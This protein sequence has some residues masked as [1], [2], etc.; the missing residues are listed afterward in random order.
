[1]KNEITKRKK[2]KKE[3]SDGGWG[4]WNNLIPHLKNAIKHEKRSGIRNELNLLTI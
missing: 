4:E 3:K 2:K 1:M